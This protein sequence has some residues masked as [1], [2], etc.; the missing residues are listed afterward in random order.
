METH[1]F[2]A[3]LSIYGMGDVIAFVLNGDVPLLT[4]VSLYLSNRRR[5]IG[6]CVSLLSQ[7]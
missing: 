4:R 2:N 5:V 1:N 6:T 7:K 3:H